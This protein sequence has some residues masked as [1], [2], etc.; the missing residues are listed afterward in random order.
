MTAARDRSRSAVP[1]PPRVPTPEL[2][3]HLEPLPADPGPLRLTAQT[4]SAVDL[5]G[6]AVASM[7]DVQLD[8][9]VLDR[10]RAAGGSWREVALADCRIAGADLAAVEAHDLSMLRCELSDTRLTG[11]RLPGARLRAVRLTDVRADLSSWPGAVL[12]HVVLTRCDLTE[13][14][15]TGAA[16]TDVLLEVCDLTGARLAGLR[17]SRVR[18]RGCR[19]DGVAGVSGLRGASVSEEDAYRLLPAMAREL[20]ITIAG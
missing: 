13:A 1:A 11:A 16:L 7:T 17:C 9:S 14:D 2:A 20:G 8:G 19:L 12:E 18:L 15:L 4:R 5:S 3:R 10:L 6:A